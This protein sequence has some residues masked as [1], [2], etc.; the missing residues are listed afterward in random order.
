MLGSYIVACLPLPS[1][2]YLGN[3]GEFLLAPIAPLL[4]LIVTGLVSISWWIL[5]LL[6]WPIGRIGI[7]FPK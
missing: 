2:Y 4:L 6:M 7:L 1:K 5:L 3:R